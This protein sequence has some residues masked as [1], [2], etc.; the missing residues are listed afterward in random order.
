MQIGR[1][2]IDFLDDGFFVMDGGVLFGTVPRSEWEDAMPPDESNQV[3]LRSRCLLLRDGHSVIL[4]DSGLGNHQNQNVDRRSGIQQ[5]HGDLNEHLKSFGLA[6]DDVTDVIHCSL[7]NTSCG[8][9]ASHSAKDP[10][11]FRKATYWL[12]QNEWDFAAKPCIYLKAAFSHPGIKALKAHGKKEF[13]D[14]D[15]EPFPGIQ[16]KVAGG[17]S[18]HDQVVLVSEKGKSFCFLGSFIPTA[19]HVDSRAVSARDVTPLIT[20]QSKNTLLSRALKE[21]WILGFQNDPICRTG[22]LQKGKGKKVSVKVLEEEQI[23]YWDGF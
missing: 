23:E 4:V 16:L 6:P 13:L 20:L 12:Q 17:T 2:Q 11:H 7:Q 18:G 10:C 14:G 3:L 1:W 21:E 22:I 9:D 19:I 5:P 15:A 8:W